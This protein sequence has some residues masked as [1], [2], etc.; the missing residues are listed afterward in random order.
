MQLFQHSQH[1]YLVLNYGTLIIPPPTDPCHLHI[2]FLES[3]SRSEQTLPHEVLEVVKYTKRI[4]LF[5]LFW[6]V[7]F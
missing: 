4:F 1:N 3:L 7:D 6:G 5:F 2:T